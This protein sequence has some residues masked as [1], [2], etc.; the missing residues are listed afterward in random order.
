MFMCASARLAPCMIKR[1]CAFTQD[2]LIKNRT[3][4]SWKVMVY[5]LLGEK[6]FILK[7]FGPSAQIFFSGPNFGPSKIAAQI[8]AASG[9][10]KNTGR[11]TASICEFR[12]MP[13]LHLSV[14]L[15]NFLYKTYIKVSKI[16]TGRQYYR[17]ERKTLSH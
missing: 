10:K 7:L 17:T 15:L 3:P 12:H 16:Q 1:Y 2:F 5:L 4:V 14:H 6:V 9:P 11:R 8:W 13:A